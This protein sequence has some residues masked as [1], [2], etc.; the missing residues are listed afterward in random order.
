MPE[1]PVRYSSKGIGFRSAN[2]PAVVPRGAVSDTPVKAKPPSD[3][4]ARTKSSN[5]KRR[6][7]T[8][9]SQIVKDIRSKRS[10]TKEPLKDSRPVPMNVNQQVGTR[11]DS[12]WDKGKELV[13]QNLAVVA[14]TI[15]RLL[16][17]ATGFNFR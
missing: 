5:Q 8:N 9:Q 10:C 16:G 3:R 2:P 13:G 6:A 14:P 7:K 1:G 17:F 4:S 15:G 12:S 11:S